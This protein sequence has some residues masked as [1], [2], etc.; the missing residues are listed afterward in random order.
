MVGLKWPTL[1]R[2]DS[3]WVGVGESEAAIESPLMRGG[4]YTQCCPETVT[5][6]FDNFVSLGGILES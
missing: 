1:K 2:E 4:Y 5:H 3:T 6:L